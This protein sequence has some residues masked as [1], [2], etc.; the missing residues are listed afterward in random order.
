MR[1]H[2]VLLPLASFRNPTCSVHFYIVRA[3]CLAIL[4]FV[5]QVRQGGVGERVP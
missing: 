2:D 3:I 1:I 4:I 5:A